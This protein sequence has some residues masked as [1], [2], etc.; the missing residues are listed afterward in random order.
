LQPQPGSQLQNSMY[1]P[2]IRQSATRAIISR[3]R[4]RCGL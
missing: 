2:V 3:L 1:V 4:Q